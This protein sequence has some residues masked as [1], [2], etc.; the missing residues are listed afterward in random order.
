[1]AN[2]SLKILLTLM[3]TVILSCTTTTLKRDH[4]LSAN[5][6][7]YQ[8]VLFYK[9]NQPHYGLLI[10]KAPVKG[11]F[12][13]SVQGIHKGFVNVASSECGVNT[14]TYYKDSSRV[15]FSLDPTL[16][17]CLFSITVNPDFA[18][19]ENSGEQWSS[20]SGVVMMK[21]DDR[22]TLSNAHQIPFSS[23]TWFSYIPKESNTRV[24]AK[25]C[26]EHIDDKVPN[27]LQTHL[28][29]LN[30][31]DLCVLEGFYKNKLEDVT[32][33]NLLSTYSPQFNK[34]PTPVIEITDTHLL[35]KAPSEVSLIVLNSK[36]YFTSD[37]KLT[38]YSFPISLIFYTTAGR[39]AYCLIPDSKEIT[40]L[41]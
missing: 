20:L 5:K 18:E 19:G 16:T 31:A 29:S 37:L 6:A 12:S 41:N 22:T 14:S 3:T 38:S 1:M 23:F 15:E 9:D 25:G 27:R 39:S 4:Y 21:R 32:L 40:C 35:V 8:S 34:L 26:G 13:F 17:R 28:F 11:A 33:L 30:K 10:V 2:A 7:N 24:F 36:N